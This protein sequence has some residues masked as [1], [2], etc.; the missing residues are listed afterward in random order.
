MI[1]RGINNPDKIIVIIVKH[2]NEIVK[3]WWFFKMIG[4]WGSTLCNFPAATKLPNK[5]IKPTET[6]R[7]EVSDVNISPL[8][9]FFPARANETIPTKAEAIP[10]NPLSKATI[11]GIWIIFTLLL[12][13]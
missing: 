8:K 1:P 12:K 9:P 4:F 2:N 3:A 5:V 10:P 6:A 13:T 11:W 7:E